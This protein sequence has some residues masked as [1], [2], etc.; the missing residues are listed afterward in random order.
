MDC[1]HLDEKGEAQEAAHHWNFE[2]DLSPSVFVDRKDAGEKGIEEE[3]GR[4]AGAEACEVGPK[5][6]LRSSEP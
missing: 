5:R 6:E 2:A 4:S 3:V 1:C